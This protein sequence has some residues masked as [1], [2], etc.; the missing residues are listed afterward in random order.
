MFRA[1]LGA[2]IAVL[3]CAGA[4][5]AENPSLPQVS[6][7]ARPGPD[8]LYAAAPYAPQLDN[9]PPFHA[10]PILV[11]GASAYR[12]G[13]FLYQDFLHDDRGAAG[14]GDPND[15]L[16]A[17]RVQFKG[18][19]GTLT[20]PTDAKYVNNTADLVELRVKPLADATAF[21]VTLNSMTDPQVA[22]FTIAIGSSPAARPWPDS[23]GTSSPA[24]LFLTVHGDHAQLV[25]AAS[26]KAI[27]PAPAA[28]FDVT[29]RQMTVTVPHAAWDPGRSVVRLAAGVGLWDAAAGHYAVPGFTASA[30]QPGGAAPDGAAIFN[31][32]FRASEPVPDGPPLGATL[33]DSSIAS[34]VNPR[35]WRELSQANALA[36]GDVSQFFANVDF[37]RLARG[38]DDDSAVP[39]TGP[40]DRIVPDHLDLGQGID[41]AKL[42]GRFPAHCDG[43]I[44]EQLQAYT[45]YVPDKPQPKGGWGLT[46]LPHA[47]NENENEYDGSRWQAALGDRGTGYLVVT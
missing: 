22:A 15:P 28:R 47:L 36:S 27:A 14:N 7:G 33:I 44:P 12:D 39:R 43:A 4:A 13:E 16:T 24:A 34:G 42:C 30:T 32:A 2:L 45:V 46:M 8:L 23:A 11:S 3:V 40:I 20:Y 6:S 18:K 31:L 21:R 19:E 9:L 17:A 25:D 29:R 38:V 41:V 1:Q 26:G 10:P 35:W 5:R 37:D